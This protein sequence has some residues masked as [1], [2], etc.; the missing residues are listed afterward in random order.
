M[1]K[2]LSKVVK[3]ANGGIVASLEGVTDISTTLV[4]AVKRITVN[5][6]NETGDFLREGV[7]VPAAIVK[8]V[9]TGLGELGVSVSKA[10]KGVVRGTI[11]GAKESGMKQE[12][13]VRGAVAETLYSAKELGLDI[14]ETAVSAVSGAIEGVT[15]IGG[16]TAKASFTAIRTALTVAQEIGDEALVQVKDAL[17]KSVKGA[18]NIITEIEK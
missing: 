13:V 2:F 18:K 16:D 6:L 11:E 8:G 5:T 12:N 7:Q 10:V 4:K 3:A 15:T 14:G 1:F 9:L 17:S